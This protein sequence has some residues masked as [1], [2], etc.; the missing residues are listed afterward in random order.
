MP[1]HRFTHSP[2]AVDSLPAAASHVQ[3]PI[4]P[5]NNH[6]FLPNR[7]L[8][9]TVSHSQLDALFRN[10]TTEDW[11]D[12]PPRKLRKMPKSSTLSLAMRGKNPKDNA[13]MPLS[14]KSPRSPTMP[15]EEF[16]TPNAAFHNMPQSPASPKPRKDSKSIFSNFGANKSSSRL[17]QDHANKAT[18]E[19]AESSPGLYSNGRSG[20]STPDLGRPVRTP[21]SDGMLNA[22]LM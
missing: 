17:N 3:R 2:T 9:H 18:N 8:G 1:Q 13:S 10:R 5:P 7:F 22:L 11:W 21:N 6:F 4:A 16:A 20:S 12:T 19:R 15:E 14:P